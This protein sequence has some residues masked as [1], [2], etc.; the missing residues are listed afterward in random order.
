MSNAMLLPAY[1]RPIY[2]RRTT[3]SRGRATCTDRRRSERGASTHALS[4]IT[5]VSC[6]LP[7]AFTQSAQAHREDLNRGK[8]G[9]NISRRTAAILA[10]AHL[11]ARAS[12]LPT[13][14]FARRENTAGMGEPSLLRS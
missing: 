10:D 7:R 14:T 13:G 2:L 11:T 9:D 3:S 1:P 12:P 6:H 5:W 4:M 8:V